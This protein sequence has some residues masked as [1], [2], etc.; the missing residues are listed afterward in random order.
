MRIKP[1]S[2]RFEP[3]YPLNRGAIDLKLEWNEDELKP[4]TFM[5][6]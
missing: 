6:S 2:F 1:L 4:Q 3:F 5:R